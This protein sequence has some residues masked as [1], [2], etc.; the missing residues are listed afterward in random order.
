MVQP[1]SYKFADRFK[2]R[3]RHLYFNTSNTVED[4][5][6][7]PFLQ[8]LIIIKASPKNKLELR[9]VYENDCFFLQE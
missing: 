9:S 4:A 2:F 3:I 5:N 8:S 6:A 7:F 1:H